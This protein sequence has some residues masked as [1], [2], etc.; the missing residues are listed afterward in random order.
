M[1]RGHVTG[2]KRERK[3][4][5]DWYKQIEEESIRKIEAAWQATSASDEYYQESDGDLVP[6]DR[7]A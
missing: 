7:A 5:N 2:T 3:G 1:K 6:W 4:A